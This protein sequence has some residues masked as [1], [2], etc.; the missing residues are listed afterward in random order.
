MSQVNVSD[1]EQE[2]ECVYDGERFSVRDN[3]AVLRHAR[4][5][6]RRRALDSHW[7]F[8]NESTSNPYLHIAGIRIHRIVATAFHGDP[9]DPKY[10]VDHIDSNCKNNRPANLRWLTRLENSLKNP[11]TRKKIEYLCGSIEAFLDNPSMLN[12]IQGDPNFGWMRAV[13]LE[14]ARNCWNRM[15]VWTNTESK[16]KGARRPVKQTSSFGDRVYKP[17]QKWEIGLGREPGLDMAQTPWCVQYMWSAPMYFPLCPQGEQHSRLD[18][19]FRNIQ[20]GNVVAYSDYEDFCPQLTA[21]GAALL[22]DGFS[23]LVIAESKNGK[24]VIV[25]IQLDEKTQHFFHFIVGSYSDMQEAEMAFNSKESQCD[26][27]AEGYANTMGY[28]R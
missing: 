24:W 3:G 25:G 23:I 5:G 1:F 20:L 6:M 21:V 16:P 2:I 9:P 17:L 12:E 27:W 28:A 18:V 19:Y 7:M 14:E 15:E 22:K 26:F 8:G 4:E 11:T 10:V 13:S